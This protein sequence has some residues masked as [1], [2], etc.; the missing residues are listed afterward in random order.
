METREDGNAGAA[1][2]AAGAEQWEARTHDQPHTRP[3]RIV[4]LYKSKRLD[5]V[6]H[7]VFGDNGTPGGKSRV[8]PACDQPSARVETG[9]WGDSPDVSDPLL[10]FLRRK[11]P[12]A[13]WPYP[14]NSNLRSVV[15]NCVYERRSIAACPKM[16]PRRLASS[17]A[18]SGCVNA[19]SRRHGN[20]W[21][22][23][24]RLSFESSGRACPAASPRR[25]WRRTFS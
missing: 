9:G 5:V 19:T 13:D 23:C 10:R 12:V 21:N 25:T 22:T 4:R 17:V 18:S 20:W 3:S 14:G 16:P 7:Q 15:L 11:G 1:R 24:T 8:G 6:S 2:R